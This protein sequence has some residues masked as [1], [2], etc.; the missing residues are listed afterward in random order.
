[1]KCESNCLTCL[2]ASKPGVCLSCRSG[3]YLNEAVCVIGGCSNNCLAC[4][5][6]TT[7]TQCSTGYTLFKDIDN[8]NQ[9]IC[10][11]AL[12][13]AE[14]VRKG[15]LRFVFLVGMVFILVEMIA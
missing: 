10:A 7:C 4:S 8:N 1:M 5:S 15:K 13:R 2:S 12:I 6:P 14:V 9:M 11:N 3:A